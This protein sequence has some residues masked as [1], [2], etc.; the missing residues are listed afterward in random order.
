MVSLQ[1]VALPLAA[2][3]F[4]GKGMCPKLKP[5]RNKKT[6]PDKQTFSKALQTDGKEGF[7]GLDF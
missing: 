6:Q 3:P 1:R 2:C 4:T 7:V 5:K